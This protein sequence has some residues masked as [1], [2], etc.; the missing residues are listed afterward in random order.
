MSARKV[1]S[2]YERNFEMINKATFC[3][4]YYDE[5]Y[6]LPKS[7]SGTKIAYEYAIKKKKQIINL[8]KEK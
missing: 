8:C 7:N 5:N 6:I 1:E 2:L 3:I 4:F